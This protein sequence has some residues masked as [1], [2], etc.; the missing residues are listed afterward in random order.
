MNVL[1]GGDGCMKL[2]GDKRRGVEG[3]NGVL[4]EPPLGSMSFQ[5]AMMFGE[6]YAHLLNLLIILINGTTLMEFYI[7]SSNRPQ[8]SLKLC[9]RSEP[10]HS[11][12]DKFPLP[13]RASL[14]LEISNTFCLCSCYNYGF[15][16]VT[17]ETNY[18]CL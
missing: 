17:E 10:Q 3:G 14:R 1:F 9:L 12:K 13:W 16:D 7:V 6:L 18:A 11:F 15:P 5:F 8:F 4:F 2:C